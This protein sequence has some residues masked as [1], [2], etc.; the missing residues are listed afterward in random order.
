MSISM[1]MIKRLTRNEPF[2]YI[3]GMGITLRG[4]KEKIGAGISRIRRERRTEEK[5]AETIHTPRLSEE[6]GALLEKLSSELG[7]R[8]AASAASR[9]AARRIGEVFSS[10]TDD[11]TFTTG[12]IIPGIYRWMLAAGIAALTLSFIFLLLGLPFISAALSVFF[13]ISLAGEMGKGRNPLRRF[14]PSSDAANVHAVMEP[15]EDAERT[16]IL[17]A[18][19]DSAAVSR[20][21]KSRFLSAHTAAAGFA[22][23]II[24][25]VTEMVIELFQGKLLS[26]GLPSLPMGVLIMLSFLAAVIPSLS[27]VCRKDEYS[28]GAGDNLS[29]VVSVAVLGKYFA[30]KKKAGNGLR[31]TRLVFVSFDGEEC[32]AQGSALWYRDNSH[33]L[34]NPVNINFD[35]LYKEDDLVFLSQDGNGLVPLSPELAAK[36]SLIS[37]GMGY[38][39]SVGK[40]GFLGGETDA[41]SAAGAGIPATTIT[42]MAPGVVTPAH[43][44]DDTPDKVSHEALSRAMSAAIKLIEDGDGQEETEAETDSLLENGK[45]YRLSRY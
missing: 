28:P 18:H 41:V 32:G 44:S 1:E 16:V 38:R 6:A 24:L 14:F 25:S 29:G 30:A 19:H 23:F 17:S 42:A 36:C 31:T 34:I 21:N 9:G 15:E 13:V 35:G 27:I 43:T 20:D 39:I 2:C 45:K 26:I 40:L 33:I 22:L 8:P 11:V 5:P 3:L 37:N 4:L 10:F 12:R 7:P